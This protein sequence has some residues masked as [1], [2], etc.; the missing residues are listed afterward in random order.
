MKIFLQLTF[1]L[2]YYYKTWKSLLNKS[3][4]IVNLRLQKPNL[5]DL[6]TVVYIF[7]WYAGFKTLLNN[8]LGNQIKVLRLQKKLRKMSLLWYYYVISSLKWQKTLLNWH[9]TTNVNFDHR[10]HSLPLSLWFW[11]ILTERPLIF[12][13]PNVIK[14]FVRNYWIE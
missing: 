4:E 8:S 6:F 1:A 13:E 12:P 7:I 14:L 9:Q 3:Y 5:I 2:I 11:L 10:D